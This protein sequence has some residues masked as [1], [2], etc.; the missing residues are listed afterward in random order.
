MGVFINNLI[1]KKK[2]SKHPK[3]VS[4]KKKVVANFTSVTKEELQK[5]RC[6]L[7]EYAI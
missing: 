1:D 3:T 4:V 2:D 7:Y 5:R 6:S